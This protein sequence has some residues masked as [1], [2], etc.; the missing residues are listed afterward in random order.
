MAKTFR[1]I[2][3]YSLFKQIQDEIISKYDYYIKLEDI[4]ELWGIY[5]NNHGCNYDPSSESA[6]ECF[7]MNYIEDDEYLYEE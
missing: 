3:D 5:G 7:Y 2:K 4:I 6:K 1:V